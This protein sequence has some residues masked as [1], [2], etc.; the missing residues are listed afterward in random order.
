MRT[1][2]RIFAVVLGIIL[3]VFAGS[4]FYIAV[5]ARTDGDRQYRVE[6][7]RLAEEIKNGTFT[8]LSGY[9]SIVR[10]EKFNGEA[11]DFWEGGRENYLI[12]E[13]EGEYYRFDYETEPAG[14]RS[15][16]F[17]LV[18]TVTVT[19]AAAVLLLLF[20]IK[21]HILIPFARLSEL[22]Y[23]LAKGNLTIPLEES[24]YRFFGSFLWG[25]DLLRETLEKHKEEEMQLLKER[26]TI[27]LSLS[28]DIKTPLQ[29]IKLYAKALLKFSHSPEKNCEIAEKINERADE[30]DGYV[31]EITRT[32]KEDFFDL[33]VESGE[34]YL[35][36]AIRKIEA[37]YAD[38][39]DFLK[40]EFTI[41]AY[42][43]CIVK[44]D[45]ERVIEVLQNLM[46]NAIK[47]G[48][49]R[50]IHI[51]FSEEEDCRLITVEN[52]GEALPENELPYIFDSFW[53]G[54]NVKSQSGSGLGLY[55]CRRLLSKMD[56]E[57]FAAGKTESMSVTVLLRK[58]F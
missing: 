27:C 7:K 51:T 1:F 22:P 16:L 30:I 5:C 53:R 50:K 14:N 45:L 52:S 24:K 33:T 13:I 58:S 20:F 55:I 9:P 2:N 40:T 37:Y 41:D 47:Y 25:M 36:E 4:N 17:I 19:L 49:G 23:E 31:R 34:F 38:K 48:D 26:K 29:A 10:V 8:D 54:S 57:I 28:H 3:L 6:A 42:T 44:G 15:R 11:K 12:K 32:Q 18:N 46:E 21:K 39:L 43:D 35:S 56:G